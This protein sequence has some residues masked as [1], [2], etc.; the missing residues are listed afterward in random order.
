MSDEAAKE[1]L[2]E[3]KSLRRLV[4][5][6]PESKDA[7][8]TTAE[9]IKYT[10]H[11]SSSAFYRWASESGALNP[12]PSATNRTANHEIASLSKS[13]VM[14]RY[15]LARTGIP[16]SS[17]V[18]R[19]ARGTDCLLKRRP[20]QSDLDD[21]L[22]EVTR[23]V[24]TSQAKGKLVLELT[25]TPNG[26]GVGE[27]PLFKVDDNVKVTL[28]KKKRLSQSFFADEE[29]NLTRRNPN[30]DEMKLTVVSDNPGAKAP[31]LKAANS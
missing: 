25:I 30:Q 17:P 24:A 12:F 21:A 16:S 8:L 11:R 18:T 27:V 28:P 9:A 10:R 23:H 7:V 1:I 26:T 29:S 19:G 3:L 5:I 2:A 13:V 20:G 4:E 14:W 15:R 31:A 22:R 6:K